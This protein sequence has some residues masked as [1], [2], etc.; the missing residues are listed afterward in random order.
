MHLKAFLIIILNFYYI[1][2]TYYSRKS[3]LSEQLSN[4]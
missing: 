1:Y 4:W 2:E 3:L